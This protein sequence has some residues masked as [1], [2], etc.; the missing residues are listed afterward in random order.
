MESASVRFSIKTAVDLER[1]PVLGTKV[2]K[3]KDIFA[4]QEDKVKKQQKG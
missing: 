3:L 2:L 1:D 4:D